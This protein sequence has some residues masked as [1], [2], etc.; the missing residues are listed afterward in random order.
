[1]PVL[2]KGFRKVEIVR[3]KVWLLERLY[4]IN[5][6]GKVDGSE[7]LRK[8]FVTLEQH[9]R[10]PCRFDFL[11]FRFSFTPLPPRRRERKEGNGRRKQGEG[12]SLGGKMTEWRRSVGGKM[13]G[14]CERSPGGNLIGW[15]RSPE[16]KMKDDG[17]GVGAAN[18]KKVAR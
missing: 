4:W 14:G 8:I 17:E 11:E 10:F 15:G 9:T 12:A 6:F 16:G 1:M 5:K 2:L 18:W 13:M 3:D 7:N